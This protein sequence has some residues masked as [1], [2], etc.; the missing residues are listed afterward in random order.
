MLED[1]FHRFGSWPCNVEIQDTAI[2]ASQQPP[3]VANRQR[4]GYDVLWNRGILP[5]VL[6]PVAP[7]PEVVEVA[8]CGDLDHCSG[9]ECVVCYADGSGGPNSSDALLRRASWARCLLDDSYSYAMCARWAPLAGSSQT[10]PKAE[11]TALVDLMKQ[12]PLHLLL[13]V[14]I[15]VRIVVSG[16]NLMQKYVNLPGPEPPS[17]LFGPL[18]EF[19]QGF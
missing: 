5:L 9:G 4:G 1:G 13:E 19:W 15:D 10:V 11:L 17:I 7:V 14:V 6:C 18:G 12:A 8:S 3:P 2:T 16:A